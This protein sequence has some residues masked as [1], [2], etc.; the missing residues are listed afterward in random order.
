M[1]LFDVFYDGILGLIFIKQWSPNEASKSPDT[2][3]DVYIYDSQS[4]FD[5]GI[6]QADDDFSKQCSERD[7]SSGRRSSKV[8]FGNS[9]DDRPADDV[10]PSPDP[11]KQTDTRS[12]SWYIWWYFRYSN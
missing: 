9:S 10:D 5:D 1:K 4:S 12:D 11:T 8:R 6:A 7:Y 3:D 2:P